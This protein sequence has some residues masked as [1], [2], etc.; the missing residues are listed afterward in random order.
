MCLQWNI[1][2]PSKRNPVIRDNM[3]A[4]GGCYAK[5][6]MPDTEAK[7]LHRRRRSRLKCLSMSQRLLL[8]HIAIISLYSKLKH[9][10]VGL[11]CPM[12][13]FLFLASVLECPLAHCLASPSRSAHICSN[14]QMLGFCLIWLQR[15]QLQR[16]GW[17]NSL[18]G[19]FFSPLLHF[20]R[21]SANGA[22]RV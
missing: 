16:P 2:Q 4:S 10:L 18:K 9:M 12:S 20:R 14:T 21:G 17:E 13:I 5:R 6:N 22:I 7:M 15:G 1:I 8:S 19:L 3:N 11:W